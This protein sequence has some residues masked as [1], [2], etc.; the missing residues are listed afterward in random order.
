MNPF[1]ELV[2]W[3]DKNYKSL[4]WRVNPSLYTTLVSEIML[5]QTNV[6]TVIKHYAPFLNKFPDFLSLAQADENELAQAW[7]NLGYYRRAKNLHNASKFVVEKYNSTLPKDY[8]ELIKING[9]GE[10]TANAII[11]MGYNSQALA[12]DANLKRVLSRIFNL[13]STT[14]KELKASIYKLLEDKQIV[15]HINEIGWKKFNESL[16]DLG[17]IVCQANKTLCQTC[18][19]N[20]ACQTKD[21]E[22]L[23]Y[24]LIK[25]KKIQLIDLELLRFIHIK[26]KKIL[27]Y[28]KQPNQ[29]LSKQWE[30]PTFSLTNLSNFTQYPFLKKNI[31]KEKI[32]NLKTFITKYKIT[33]YPIK[34]APPTNWFKETEN[35]RYMDIKT[36]TSEKIILSSATVKILKKLNYYTEKL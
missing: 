16:M 21:K 1:K 11:A 31:H 14:D 12:L 4:P 26:D 18:P 8:S 6:N 32:P 29:W 35:F 24:P 34:K 36:I 33:N 3:S 2:I 23:K 30:L 7:E 28:Q 20:K 10:Y 25:K 22:P 17:R 19:V 9:I 5:Q 15:H 27:Y 13:K